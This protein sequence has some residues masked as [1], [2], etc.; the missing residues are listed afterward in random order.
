MTSSVTDRRPPPRSDLRRAALLEAVEEH[1]R[2]GSGHLDSI[3][4]AEVS[5]RAG[6]TRSAFYFY[7]E[8]KAA[9]V[10]A[11]SEE[12]F[13]EVVAAADM[14]VGPGEPPARIE[15]C[16]RAVHAAW[17]RHQHLFRAMLEA[18]ASSAAVRE[19]WEADHQ[20]FFPPVLALVEQERAAGRAP[21][22]VDA[23]A[24]ATVLL[25]LNERMLER[26]TAG[27]G[28][29]EQLVEAVIAVWLRTLYGGTPTTSR[30]APA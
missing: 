15:A 11:A 18:R 7:F 16:V 6:V 2:E 28:A 20:P 27:Y 3:S 30:G 13:A 24:L 21:R 14:L 12:F 22:D 17:V 10:A 9:A 29:P 8:N 4:I 23:T 25:D 19:M 1:L 26:L 5:R